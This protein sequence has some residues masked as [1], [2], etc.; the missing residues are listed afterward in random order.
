MDIKELRAA[1]KTAFDAAQ[2]ALTA[3]EFDA[4]KAQELTDKAKALK[5][6]IDAFD[7][8]MPPPEPENKALVTVVA[9]EEDKAKAAKTWGFGEFARALA[10]NPDSV[11]AYQSTSEPGYYNLT[12][13]VGQKAI[14]SLASARQKAIT[15]LSETVPA[16]GGFLVQTDWG[17]A[18]MDRVYADGQIMS[19]VNTTP[20]SANANGIVFYASAESNR[21][22]GNRWGGMLAYWVAEG[23]E[24]TISHQTYRRIEL[25]LNKLVV[26]VPAT[27]ELL[28]DTTALGA[29]IQRIG[30]SEIRFLTE[31]AIVN[32]TGAGQPL[33][34]MAS[35]A[36]ITQAAEA[37]QAAATIVSENILNMWSR[38]WVGYTDYV[39]LID[40]SVLPQLYQMNLGVGTGGALT[41]M[42]PG[43]LS[44]APYGQMMGRPLIPTEHNAV[45]GTTGDI[46]LWSP[47]SYR[48]IEK[49]GIQTASSIHVRWVYDETEFRMVFRY[50]GQPEWALPLTPHS[51]GATQGPMV[52]LATRS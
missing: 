40:Q 1:Y 49:G 28:Q 30:A 43:G 24:K 2:A 16:D 32:G 23:G 3:G 8:L 15:G 25:Q 48:A 17:G 12:E 20:I 18:L 26:R 7:A 4:D 35:P 41:F 46:I 29:E 9:D 45:L 27:D 22:D 39:W 11:R 10:L 19:L 21:T 33:G 37:G 13:A 51:G 14:G 36:L 44:Q 5:G 50:D 38:R 6:R 31:E 47:S 34:I 52:V 42:P